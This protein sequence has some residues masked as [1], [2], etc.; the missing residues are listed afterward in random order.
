MTLYLVMQEK[1]QGR[2]TV[3]AEKSI[4]MAMVRTAKFNAL[5]DMVFELE[6]QVSKEVD[7]LKEGK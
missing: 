5:N 1:V 6:R 7:R 3:C 4:D 2:R